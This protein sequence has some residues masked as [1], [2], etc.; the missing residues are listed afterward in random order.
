M[1]NQFLKALMIFGMILGLLIPVQMVKSLV[2]ER[3]ERQQEVYTE[4]G[5]TWGGNFIFGGVYA[6]SGNKKVFPKF[7]NINTEL[8]SEIRKK[9]IFKIPCFTSILVVDA[10]FDDS[11]N[12]TNFILGM[13]FSQNGNIEID[14]LKINDESII[15]SDRN[16]QVSESVWNNDIINIKSKNPL[17]KCSIRL[18]IRGS[19]R[20]YFKEGEASS[21]ITMTSDWPDPNFTGMLPT[22]RNINSKG[23][24][25]E[26]NTSSKNSSNDRGK[27]SDDVFGVSLYV[28]QN[29]YQQTDRIIK[30]ALLFIFLTFAV[31][32]IFENLSN[33]KIHPFQYLLVGG[34]LTIFY[35][36]LLSLSE[37][38]SFV[39]SY[40]IASFSTI[41]L[42]S[43]YC[44]SVLG[45]KK[46]ALI[47]CA[48]LSVLYTFLFILIQMQEYS[49]L[50]G[51]FG[52]FFLL[53]ATM[54]LTRKINWQEK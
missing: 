37:H 46:R 7:V 36:L 8:K 24:S 27:V 48:F 30:Y 23:F 43:L 52:L 39:I 9:N 47:I 13:N 11:K 2:N 34:A 42:I 26:W 20:L 32:F 5:K 45:E 40:F 49:L 19:E 44:R 31:F 29:I 33:L 38:L 18:K 1:K 3:K 10:D 51:S 16:I 14:S 53:A 4:A 21:K 22:E 17:K 6:S 54:Y 35:L 28:S 41:S 12:L 25:A 50:L 15:I